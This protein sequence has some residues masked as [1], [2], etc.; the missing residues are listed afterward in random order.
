MATL[1]LGLDSFFASAIIGFRS[2]ARRHSFIVLA[3]SFGLCDFGATLV[4]SQWVHDLAQPPAL[5]IYLGCVLLLALAARGERSGLIF[6]LPFLLSIDNLCCAREAAFAPAIGLSSC[7]LALAGLSLGA[8]GYDL[9]QR[10]RKQGNGVGIAS[11]WYTS[12]HARR[13]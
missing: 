4:G 1:D 8:V 12:R 13:V 9:L 3:V 7:A 11:C 2:L 5:A 10:L 6:G